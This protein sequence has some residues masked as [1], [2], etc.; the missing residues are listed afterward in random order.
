MQTEG[1]NI[2]QK[3]NH[4]QLKVDKKKSSEVNPGGTAPAPKSVKLYEAIDAQVPLSLWQLV[5]KL[6]L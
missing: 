4:H 1:A 6:D 5:L 2:E 3:R